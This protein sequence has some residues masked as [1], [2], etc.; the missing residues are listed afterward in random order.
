MEKIKVIRKPDIT[1]YPA[2][3]VNKDTVFEFENDNVKQTLKNLK[4]HSVTNVEGECFKSKYITDINLQEGD[5]LVYEAKDRGYIKP[6]EEMLEVKEAIE[7]L[8][9]IREV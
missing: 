1:L 5:I 9:C 4:F 8:E 6:V 7:E 3:V 2:I